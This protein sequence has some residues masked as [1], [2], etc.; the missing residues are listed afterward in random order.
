MRTYDPK[1]IAAAHEQGITHR[2]LKPENLFVTKD[3]R[4]KILD[5]GLAKLNPPRNP[6]VG[7][8]TVTQKQLTNPGTVMGT[9]A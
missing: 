8:D 2:D 5:F 1:F 4:L 3:G 7:F 9:V 6:P